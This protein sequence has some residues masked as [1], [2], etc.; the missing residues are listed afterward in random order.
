MAD[1]SSSL[2][3]GSKPT[4]K[5]TVGLGSDSSTSLRDQLGTISGSRVDIADAVLFKSTVEFAELPV[6]LIAK[7]APGQDFPSVLNGTRFIANNSS[8]ANLNYFKD[9][10]EGQEIKIRGDGF[11]TIVASAIMH[12]NTGLNKL[13]AINK[14]Y[15]FTQF[16]SIWYENA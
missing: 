14:V 4:V 2:T 11:S 10:Q 9:G 6:Q 13:L 3:L 7:F 15:T 16:L 8:A 1:S 12:T 5:N